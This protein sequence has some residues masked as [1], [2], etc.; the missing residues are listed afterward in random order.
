MREVLLCA[1]AVAAASM[2]TWSGAEGATPATPK[3][4][5]VRPLAA[6]PLETA[7]GVFFHEGLETITNL[8]ER[9]ND[10]GVDEGRFRITGTDPFRGKKSIQ[11]TY[12][13]LSE[14][15]KGAD[16]GN[17][18]WVWRFFGDNPNGR[19]EN[20][21]KYETVVARWYHKFEEGF[22]PRDGTHFPPKMARMRCFGEGSW[23]GVYTVLFWIEPPDG[24]LSIER[25]TRAPGAH[26]EWT[27]NHAANWR[28]SDPVNVGR[29]VHF[30]MRVAL[31]KGKRSDTI[32]AWADGVLVCDMVG[33]D[34][35]AGYKKFTLN[36]MSWDCYW[37]GGSPVEQSRF[38]DDLMLSTQPIGPARTGPNPVIVA[39]VS[40]EAGGWEV[41]AAEAAQEPL[42]TANTVDGVVTRHQPPAFD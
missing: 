41:E 12:R 6:D 38:Y 33:D 16:P 17:A 11:Q 21:G 8:K 28:F 23:S 35:A 40:S 36:G 26:R 31:G 20:R 32:Q 30:E 15:P 13:T 2:V 1:L 9:F 5:R 19:V 10:I 22:T 29:W 34:L 42:V 37:N 4:E 7:P 27:P 14:V 39:S 3:V 25:H 18:G 24:H